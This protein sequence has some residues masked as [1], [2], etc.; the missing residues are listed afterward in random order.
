VAIER[1][2]DWYKIA[3]EQYGAN[4]SGGS[5]YLITGFYK[6]R[7]WSLA[8]FDDATTTESRHIRVVPQDGEGT[9]TGRHWEY[10]FPV[11]Y[12]DGPGYSGNDNQTVFIRGFKIAVRD[13][14]LGWLSQAQGSKVQPV[15]AVRPRKRPCDFAMFL[16]RVFC[17]KNTPKPPRGEG[18]GADGGP[19][20]ALSQVGIMSRFQISSMTE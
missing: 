3:K 7:S 16:M 11:D 19:V 10:T 12:R 15:P 8:S 9:I 17:K 5:L 6:A 2:Y 13:D 14:V 1:A 18:G 20:L 4:I